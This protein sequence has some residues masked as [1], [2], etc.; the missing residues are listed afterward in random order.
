[1]THSE[2]KKD[3][4]THIIEWKRLAQQGRTCD[5]CN[6]TGATLRRI[7]RELNS[8]CGRSRARF[9]LK[10]T[11]LGESRLAESNAVL[12]DGRPLEQLVPG[13]HVAKTDC[14]SCGEILG[15]PS[16]C[17]AL[18][19]DGHTYEAIPAELIRA[20]V[21]RAAD[22]CGEGCECNCG[23]G[24]GKEAKMKSCA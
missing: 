11:P 7:V 24:T 2:P 16:K 15:Q 18:A 4:K 6:D 14:P 12:I 3:M 5:R 23:C 21:C 10:T 19:A 22:C 17:R 13:A 1:M 8:N 9:R 20:A